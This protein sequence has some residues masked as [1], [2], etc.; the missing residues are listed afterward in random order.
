M[1]APK[2]A[3]SLSRE[4]YKPKVTLDHRH[5]TGCKSLTTLKVGTCN[6]CSRSTDVRKCKT[7][8][9]RTDN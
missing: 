6:V 5:V 3:M 4:S 9:K 2:K 8:N 1:G 7:R